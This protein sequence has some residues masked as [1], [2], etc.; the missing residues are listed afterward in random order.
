M[1][2]SETKINN[3]MSAIITLTHLAI[4]Y[5][6]YF[7]IIHHFLLLLFVSYEHWPLKWAWALTRSLYHSALEFFVAHN[8]S[9]FTVAQARISWVLLN[10]FLADS[11]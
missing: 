7:S 11:S 8:H 1:N 6:S 2:E 4:Y 5:K 10:N 3:V 9:Y